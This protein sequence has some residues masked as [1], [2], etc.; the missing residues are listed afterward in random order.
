MKKSDLTSTLEN[1]RNECKLTKHKFQQKVYLLDDFLHSMDVDV[2][3]DFVFNNV[4][5]EFR[6]EI[7]GRTIQEIKYPE[8]WI[9]SLKER[10]APKVLLKKYP[11]KYKI[12]HVN[13]YYPYISMPNEQVYV[14]FEEGIKCE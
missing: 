4:V 14:R 3:I 13:E 2:Y 10:F 1:I 5:A 12:H 9:E 6:N 8:N 7:L 11:V